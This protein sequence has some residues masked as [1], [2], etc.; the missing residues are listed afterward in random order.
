MATAERLVDHQRTQRYGEVLAVFAEGNDFVAHVYGTQLLN[1]CPQDL[2]EGLVATDIAAEMG[3]LMV[4]LNGPRQW[5]LDG[6]G[7]KA[8]PIEPVLREFNGILMRRIAVINMGS[9]PRQEFYKDNFVDRRAVFFFNAG[10][11]VYELVRPD[12]VAYVMQALCMGVDPSMSIA[13]LD[14]LGERLALP[15]GWV[16]RVRILD[17]ELVIDTSDHVA[18]VLQDEFENSYTLPH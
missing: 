14:S 6:L 8:E 16:Y 2:W 11:K 10:E 15:D 13:S 17:E 4:K 18:T 3:A 5:V 12:G 9:N 1:D 7:S